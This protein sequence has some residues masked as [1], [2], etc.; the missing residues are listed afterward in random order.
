MKLKSILENVPG[1][2]RRPSLKRLSLKRPSLKR[3]PLKRLALGATVIIAAAQTGTAYAAKCEY[4]VA[5]DWGNGFTATIRIT[6]N[7][8]S[9]VSGWNISWNYS[10]GSRVTSNWNATLSGANPYTATP[11]NWNSNIA[12]NSSIEFGIQGTN[13][14]GKAQVPVITG[15]VCS[16]VVTSSVPSTVASTVQREP[17]LQ[18]WQAPRHVLRRV[19]RLRLCD[20]LRPLQYPSP[21]RPATGMELLLHCVQTQRAGG[22][23]KMEKVA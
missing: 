22:V 16:S 4:I 12:V 21:A 10:D 8:S 18:P 20:H 19:R 7:G 23:M 14:A 9:A 3:L 5:N 13:G 11:L 2:L 17:A 15:A 6:N 1:A